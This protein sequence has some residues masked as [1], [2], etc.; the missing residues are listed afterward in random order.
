[1]CKEYSSHLQT[2][3][4]HIKEKEGGEQA[5]QREPLK[6]RE[7]I[8]LLGGNENKIQEDLSEFMTGH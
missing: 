7:F 6:F 8:L 3:H 5:A 4:W 1:M 2:S